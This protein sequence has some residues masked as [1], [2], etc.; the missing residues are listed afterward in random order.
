MAA[1]C[2]PTASAD[3]FGL[4]RMAYGM[5][6]VCLCCSSCLCKACFGCYPCFGFH[7]RA[8]VMVEVCPCALAHA[9]HVQGCFKFCG[10]KACPCAPSFM[11]VD[12]GM[13][14]MLSMFWTPHYG[15]GMLEMCPCVL[16]CAKRVMSVNNVLET[17]VRHK[18][19]WRCAHVHPLLPGCHG[20]QPCFGLR[21]PPMWSRLFLTSG[22]FAMFWIL[23]GVIGPCWRVCV[24]MIWNMALRTP[25]C[26]TS[27]FPAA[28]TEPP[29][30]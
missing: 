28:S 12:Q 20:C 22:M 9:R 8:Y 4:R 18:A 14:R 11:D 19:C 3:P 27:Y 5:L 26:T 24:V 23:A 1:G 25:S 16:A 17:A 10:V 30:T 13:V 29:D 21:G 2:A 15:G 6:E 7:R